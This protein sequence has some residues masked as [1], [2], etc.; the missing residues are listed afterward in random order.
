MRHMDLK[1]QIEPLIELERFLPYR[2]NVVA[3]AV[4]RALSRVYGERYGMTIP[5][6]R[7]I[8]TLGQYGQ[9]T[10]KA[11]GA[12]SRMHKTKV[13]R[14][15]ASLAA[16]GLIQRAANEAD[17][18]EA[19]LSLTPRGLTV[20]RT[21]VPDIVAF[22]DRL[23]DGIGKKDRQSLDRLLGEVERRATAAWR[24]EGEP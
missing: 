4:S 24:G 10:A 16:R 8:A 22:A 3:E 1:T 7:V 15:V 23:L 5:E 18:R 14:A 13:S 6:W 12:H 19:F 11:I 21:L 20:Y 17:L 2:L 9:M